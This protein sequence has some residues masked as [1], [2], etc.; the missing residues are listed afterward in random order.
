MLSS[1]TLRRWLFFFIYISICFITSP[2][3]TMATEDEQTTHLIQTSTATPAMFTWYKKTPVMLHRTDFSVSPSPSLVENHEYR[4]ENGFVKHHEYDTDGGDVIGVSLFAP[5][6]S[7][8]YFPVSNTDTC[9]V[10]PAGVDLSS[11]GLALVFDLLLTLRFDETKEHVKKR[12]RQKSW[13]YSL[14]AIRPKMTFTEFQ[15]AVR[16]LGWLPCKI[17]ARGTT[18]ELAKD[19]DDLVDVKSAH[20]RLLYDTI[21]EWYEQAHLPVD[22]M[23]ALALQTWIVDQKPSIEMLLSNKFISRKILYIIANTKVENISSASRLSSIADLIEEKFDWDMDDHRLPPLLELDGLMAALDIKAEFDMKTDQLQEDDKSLLTATENL[24][25]SVW[26]ARSFWEDAS[27]GVTKTAIHSGDSFLRAL[28]ACL[29]RSDLKPPE[30]V[31]AALRILLKE[32]YVFLDKLFRARP[33][34]SDE[35]RN[36]LKYLQSEFRNRF[37]KLVKDLN[38]S[39][40]R[41]AKT[42]DHY[43]MNALLDKKLSGLFSQLTENRNGKGTL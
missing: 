33:H 26:L 11:K 17:Y 12:I 2:N 34:L 32:D 30:R 4:M 38:E 6:T 10:L 13:H 36:L 5:F 14:V 25:S 43:S 3:H 24:L 40:E 22:K 19:R 16:S 20:I 8:H 15:N 21:A 29:Q 39:W 41:H 37:A 7:P 18:I 9:W 31:E 35:N 42:Q 1:R 28:H 23:E 27:E